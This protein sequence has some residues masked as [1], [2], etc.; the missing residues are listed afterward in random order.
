VDGV[1][2]ADVRSVADQE[3]ALDRGKILRNFTAV[4]RLLVKSALMV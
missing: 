3:A 4:A 1:G 2:E